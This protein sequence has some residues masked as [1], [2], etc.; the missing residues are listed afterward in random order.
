MT[1]PRIALTVYVALALATTALLS[2]AV[3]AQRTRSGMPGREAA[4][5]KGAGPEATTPPAGPVAGEQLTVT[6]VVIEGN[7]RVN[8][9]RIAAQMKLRP[10]SLY[11]ND[12]ANADYHRIFDLHEFANVVL[13]PERVAGGIRLRVTVDELALLKMLAT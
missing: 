4:P 12:E 5:A 3:F 2:P 10:G 6:E 1:N 9:N 7:Q 13:T 11:S 8:A